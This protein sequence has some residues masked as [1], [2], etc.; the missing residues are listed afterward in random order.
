MYKLNYIL[1]LIIISTATL[2]GSVT[3]NGTVV[4]ES[5]Q[6]PISDVNVT[7]GGGGVLLLTNMENFKLIRIQRF[8]LLIT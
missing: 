8:Y 4:D 3:V 1:S 5:N 7:A 2:F 6:S